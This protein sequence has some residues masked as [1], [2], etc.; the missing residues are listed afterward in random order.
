[1]KHKCRV[2]DCVPLSL[3]ASLRPGVQVD[4]D[5]YVDFGVD[6]VTFGVDVDLS[7]GRCGPPFRGSARPT[8]PPVEPSTLFS[9]FG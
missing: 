7:R 3:S 8:A 1:M 5:L 2:P 6:V 9:F 4:F